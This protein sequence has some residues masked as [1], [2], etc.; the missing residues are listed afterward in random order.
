M[1]APQEFN[2]YDVISFFMN[3]IEVYD[4]MELAS[5]TQ[6]QKIM[7]EILQNKEHYETS[8]LLNSI[9]FDYEMKAK[10]KSIIW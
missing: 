3:R 10:N 4:Q 9:Y 5:E 2:N 7:E 6:Q 8:E 1:Q